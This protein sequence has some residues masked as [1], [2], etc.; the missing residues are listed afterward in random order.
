[1]VETALILPFFSLI[2]HFHKVKSIKGNIQ[3]M[4][5]IDSAVDFI[6]VS[7]YS[8]KIIVISVEN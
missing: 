7:S 6:R 2:L 5:K 8:D 3:N 1:M 4:S